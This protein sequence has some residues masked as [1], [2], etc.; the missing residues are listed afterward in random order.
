[1]AVGTGYGFD[2]SQL[3]A[4]LKRADEA[5]KTLG[6]TGKTAARQLDEAFALAKNG[7]I[8][9]FISVIDRLSNSLGKKGYNH[10]ANMVR[11]IATETTGAID[12]VNRFATL[13]QTI[14]DGGRSN[15]KNGAIESLKYQLDEAL[16]R[17]GVLNEQLQFFT[18]GEGAKAVGANVVDTSAL[19]QEANQLRVVVELLQRRIEHEQAL[20]ALKQRSGA[21]ENQQAL[22]TSWQKMEEE[23]TKRLQQQSIDAKEANKAYEQAYNDRYQMY[24]VM[25]D[26][27]WQEDLKYFERQN[28]NAK[29]GGQQYA[30]EYE[31]KTRFYERW[32][33]ETYL[34]EQERT[35]QEAQQAN[36]R[37]KNSS[38]SY[39]KGLRE[40]ERFYLD[41]IN[42]TFEA[43]EK[44]RKKEED[45]EKKKNERLYAERAKLH[46]EANQKQNQTYEGAIAFSSTAKTLNR[47][48]QAVKNLEAARAKLSK[49]DADYERKLA[50]I[51]RHIKQHND[52]IDKA[53]RGTK[54]LR[55]EHQSLGQ[56]AGGLGRMLA[57]AFSIQAIRGYINQMVKVRGEMEMQQRALQAIL[58]NK[59]EAD[60]IW[61]KTIELAVR[62]P[63]RIKD[64]VTYTKQLAAYRVESDKLYDTNKM[65]AD[66]S[67]GLGVDMSRLILAFGQ[68]K[69]ANYLRGTEL[70]QF[71]EAGINMLGELSKYFTELEGR[72]VSVGD[73]FERISKRMVSFSDVEEIFK[74]ITSEGGTFYRM[75]EI[76]AETLKGQVS[77]LKDSIDIMLNEMGKAND[78]TLKTMVSLTKSV[79]DNWRTISAIVIPIVGALIT[80]WGIFRIVTTKNAEAIAGFAKTFG[81]HFDIVIT[82]LTRGTRVAKQFAK[83]TGVSIMSGWTTVIL[84]VVAAL[85]VLIKTIQNANRVKKELETLELSGAFDASRSVAEYKRLADV[86]ADTSK[87]YDEQ[88]KALTTLKTKYADILPSHLLEAKT[89]KELAG[90]YEEAKN[91]I[92]DYVAAKTK[93]KQIDVIQREEGQNVQKQADD[94]ANDI[95]NALAKVAP[96]ITRSDVIPIVN[97]LQELIQMGNVDLFN[98]DETLQG[99]VMEFTGLEISTNA[100]KD[101]MGGVYGEIS[102]LD[103]NAAQLV[104]S[105]NNLKTAMDEV[106]ASSLNWMDSFVYQDFNK[107]KEGYEAQASAI[108]KYYDTIRKYQ[109]QQTN[110]VKAGEIAI[111]ESEMNAATDALNKIFTDANREA[112]KWNEIINEPFKLNEATIAANKLLWAQMIDDINKMPILPSQKG[113]QQKYVEA[114]GQQME[115]F[116]GTAKQQEVARIAQELATSMKVSLE[117]LDELFLKSDESIS[118]YAKRISGTLE[119]YKTG[120]KEFDN[121]VANSTKIGDYTKKQVDLMKTQ[122]PFLIE[123]LKLFEAF[124][125]PKKAKGSTEDTFSPMLRSIKE[126]YD[127]FKRLKATFDEVTAKEGA[128]AK[129]GD[130]F[131]EA[132]GKT[133]EEMGFDL[134]SQ[135]G[136]EA[137]YD[138]LISRAP[139]AKKKIQAKLA[140]G[141]VVWDLKIKTREKDNEKLAKDI[142]DMLDQYDLSLEL[143]KLNIPPDV[144]KSLFGV[145]SIGLEDIRKKVQQE[146]NAAKLVGGNEDRIK[147]LEKD[148]EKINDM[149]DKAQIERLQTYL[150]YT[151]AAIGE[152]AKIKAEEL[153]KLKEIEDTFRKAEKKAETEADK[154]RIQEQKA[155]AE[156]GVRR[157]ANEA[158]SKMEWEEFRKSETFISLFD[159]LEGASD[160]ILKKAIEDL[161]KFKK[162]WKD[163]P[164][165]QMKEVIELRNKAQRALESKKSPWGE[166][167][168]LKGLIS[169]D[170]RTREQAELDSYN[171]EQEKARLENE[172]EMIGLINQ[173]R[174]EGTTNEELKIVLGEKYSHLLDENVNLADREKKLAEDLIPAQDKA[175]DRAQ[176]RIQNEKDLIDAYKKQEETLREI[177]G[178]AN[179][180]YDSFKELSEALG[181]D[182]DGPAALFA[183][184]GMSMANSVLNAIMLSAQLKTI[185]TG[186]MAAG[187]ALNAA[188]GVI[189]WIVMGVQL[190]TQII[191]AIAKMKDNQIVAQ[192]EEQ[193]KLIE[194]QRDI[195]EQIEERVEKAYSVGQLEAYNKE[196]EKS[197][198]LEIQALE[199]SIA[200]E[201]SR[202]K[203][204]E[205][206]IAT[207][208]KEI[209][210]ARKRLA[211]STQEMM[212]EMG[213][214]FDLTDFASGFVDA[215]WDAM[216]E[217][218]SGLD[219]LSEHFDETMTDMVKKQALYK[220]ASKIMEQLQKAINAGLEEDYSIDQ[221]EWDAIVDAANKANIDLDKFLEGYRALFG[222]LSLGGEGGLSGLSKG[223]QGIT[224]DT[225][226][227]IEAYLNSIR[228]YTSEQVEY[229]KKIYNMFYAMTTGTVNGLNVR[230]IS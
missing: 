68:V 64:L 183:D 115:G 111:K 78:S 192:L 225:A 150:K 173:K 164:L 100:W 178:M 53:T 9:D 119:Q 128:I 26:K 117:G 135:E 210:D 203:S 13:M 89:I 126:I 181:G 83:S 46:R 105:I 57:S 98:V 45:A 227:I 191:S 230:L 118:D 31:D 49:T 63:F 155:L 22:D 58:Q 34:K 52:N 99:L 55:K 170:G 201:K 50:N 114:L 213:G 219:A 7:N 47:E 137:A 140:K 95:K 97:K 186:A 127:E 123:F 144:A 215:W 116:G 104:V 112:P 142:Q 179:D 109:E 113:A 79:V 90:N 196:L 162:E 132:F 124:L 130:A 151:R 185:E 161:D 171:A 32:I 59:D 8:Q 69:A 106:T 41:W 76:Q 110:G 62:S 27:M 223:I 217:G 182:E 77:N 10:A 133:P 24:A 220:G 103:G 228:A 190:L 206:Q 82:Q 88:Q 87:S 205:E 108:G 71:S 147:Q 221:A 163:L 165:D 139:D 30:K 208:E 61:Q 166:A 120:I 93:E 85:A 29:S 218:K 199:A 60:A 48:I 39:Q 84:A 148:L 101:S 16:S 207:W 80:R 25:Y 33:N 51:N 17:L 3:D 56:A 21:I 153:T 73:V 224:E 102:V 6:K 121:D 226:Q 177:Q 172:L 138:Y 23:R 229:T 157:E 193:A 44:R 67:S 107:V 176:E 158:M 37:A 141:E 167:K 86:V 202:K 125:D 152:R 136:I 188:M 2:L 1:M 197:V 174:A 168:R 122:V 180:L 92:Y 81:R 145:E 204:D 5:L 70:R 94:L 38:A 134:F 11:E 18:K 200:L 91:A 211:E 131:K 66:V 156:S 74:R 28:A 35:Q 175:I 169:T 14:N 194:R 154:K 20:A 36:E 72:A 40:K 159:D 209:L 129:F 12:R 195:Y 42:K 54:E 15:V 143:K 212:E 160:A 75:Q 216:E 149:E 222:Q 19:Q 146:L 4:E 189:G 198:D 214:I 184:M 65:L 96:N 43:D 187:T